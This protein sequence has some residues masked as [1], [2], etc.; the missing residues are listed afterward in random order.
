MNSPQFPS[1]F[2]V[3]P[4][5]V[6]LRH[7]ACAPIPEGFTGRAGVLVWAD[8]AGEHADHAFEPVSRGVGR[9]WRSLSEDDL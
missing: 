6:L 8:D 1:P 7:A 2:G 9:D 5:E 4:S 3:P